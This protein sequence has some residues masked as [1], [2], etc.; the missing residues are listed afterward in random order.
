MATAQ[1]CRQPGLHR[2]RPGAPGPGATI[3]QVEKDPRKQ[4][5]RRHIWGFQWRLKESQKGRLGG[6]FQAP[7]VC[8]EPLAVL[9]ELH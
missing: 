9:Q 7:L 1:V 4:A 5:H 3:Q 6:N 8:P 2:V